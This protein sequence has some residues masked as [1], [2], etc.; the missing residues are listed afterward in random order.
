MATAINPC[1][2]LAL[3][4]ALAAVVM[5]GC[6]TVACRS[7]P[8][9]RLPDWMLAEPRANRQP[10]NLIRLRQDPPPVYLLGPRDILG[11]FIEGVLGTAD[12][13]PPVHFPQEGD[14]PPAIGFPIPIRED[15]TLALPLI[16]PLKVSGLTLTQAE[17][18]IR[19]EYVRRNILPEERAR[20]V[21][22][23]IR[24]RT[25]QIL[26]VRE[27]LGSTMSPAPGQLLVG[28]SKRGSAYAVDL[29]AYENDVLHALTKT[30][31]LPGLDAKNEVLVLR[32]AFADAQGR[33]ALLRTAEGRGPYRGPA[34][35]A[36]R[37]PNVVHIPLREEP[38]RPPVELREEDIILTTGDVVFIE[39]REREVFYSGGLLAGRENVLPRDYD[40]DVVAAVS[41]AGGAIAGAAGGGT[42]SQ[43]FF[44]GAGSAAGIIPPTQVIVIRNLEGGGSIPIAVDLTSALVN[45]RERILIQPGD[46]V[47]LEY[48]PVEL[49]ANV[50]LGAVNF[51]FFIN[52]LRR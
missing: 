6:N 31:G 30:G 10:I 47:L 11:I 19:D 33:S 37:D 16:P 8:A 38:G 7:I 36:E 26:V 22:T 21:V 51:Q 29:P 46:L 25:Y 42:R 35:F 40:L 44:G 27:D 5:S 9:A 17:N 1:R 34:S 49:I 41:V 20:I 3:L 50:V 24:K 13:P 28:P 18:M 39:T 43:A 14:N 2:T 12:Q 32:G 15:G 4:V 48:K 45:P 52:E 23:M